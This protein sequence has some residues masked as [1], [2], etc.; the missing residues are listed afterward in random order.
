MPGQYYALGNRAKLYEKYKEFL[1][2][3]NNTRKKN[4]LIDRHR[5][6]TGY[7]GHPFQGFSKLS[8]L[9]KRFKGLLLETNPVAFLE[10]A[11]YKPT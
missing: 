7:G 1:R 4:P 11:V 8:S 10:L 9:E 3:L 5:P 6:G 2:N